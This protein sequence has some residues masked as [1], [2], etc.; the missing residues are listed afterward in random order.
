MLYDNSNTSQNANLKVAINEFIA[1]ENSDI[2][3][4]KVRKLGM[5][6]EQSSAVIGSLK[7][8]DRLLFNPVNSNSGTLI[9]GFIYFFSSVI[10]AI[11]TLTII[12]RLRTQKRWD[13]ELKKTPLSLVLRLVPYMIYFIVSITFCMGFLKNFFDFRFSG[14][15][16]A[17]LPSMV[18]YTVA[19]GMCYMILA[20][21]APNTMAA[22]QKAM[23]FVPPGF[24]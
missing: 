11:A 3:M 24:I 19:F 15:F 9:I 23:M 16:F 12:V 13:D 8:Q 22:T 17:Y 14:N 4:P 7:L 18:I 21:D 20:W 5:N 10:Y 6:S 2:G 1:T